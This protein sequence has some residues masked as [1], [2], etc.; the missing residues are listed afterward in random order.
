[1]ND[2]ICQYME[3]CIIRVPQ[4]SPHNIIVRKVGT[5]KTGSLILGNPKP[6]KSQTSLYKCIESYVFPVKGP[7]NSWKLLQFTMCAWTRSKLPPPIRR[8]VKHESNRNRPGKS[9][10]TLGR[11]IN[12]HILGSFWGPLVPENSN[13][14]V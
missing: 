5:H 1:M 9:N 12:Y 4:E 14:R 6:C 8:N 13:G 11:N 3:V 7:L 2:N 10:D